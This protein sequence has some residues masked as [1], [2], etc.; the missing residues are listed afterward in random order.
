MN[1][2]MVGFAVRRGEDPNAPFAMGETHMIDVVAARL[3]PLETDR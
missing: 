2:Q 3:D 1:I